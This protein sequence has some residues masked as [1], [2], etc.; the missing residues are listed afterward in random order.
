M[1][2][3]YRLT[4]RALDVVLA[5][6]ALLVL[7]PVMLAV[8][9]AIRVTMGSPVFFV[10]QRAGQGGRPFALLK[11][12]TMRPAA[13][14][15]WDPTTDEARLTRLGRALRRWSLDELPQLLNVIA[16][17]MSLVGPRPLPMRYVA[18]YG[19]G[20]AR[21]LEALPG[22]TGWA[23]VNGRND[24]TWARRFDLDVWYVDRRSIRLDARILVLTVRSVLTG[25]GVSQESQ[26]TMTEFMGE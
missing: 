15:E 22:I 9:V 23:Q 11:F 19:P 8:A 18:R 1:G 12:R 7:A 16:G 21:R 14:G 26:A 20:Q 17:E 3:G 13:S 24:T 2:D 5:G 6:T 4:K 10:Q 25:H